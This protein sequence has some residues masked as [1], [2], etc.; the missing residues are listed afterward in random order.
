MAMEE[1]TRKRTSRKAYRSHVSRIRNKV[2]DTLGK[3]IDEFALEYL[4]TAITQLEKKREQINDLDTR[5]FELIDNPDELE[6]TIL[7][8]FRGVTRHDFRRD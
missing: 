4:R 2:E 3:D 1:L 8:Y 6:M 5:I 7:D